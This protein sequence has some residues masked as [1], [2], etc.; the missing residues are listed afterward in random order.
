MLYKTFEK[1]LPGTTVDSILSTY[2]IDGLAFDK[3]DINVK[4]DNQVLPNLVH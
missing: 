3:F 4:M 2:L 1:K